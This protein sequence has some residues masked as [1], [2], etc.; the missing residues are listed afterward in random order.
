LNQPKAESLPKID[1]ETYRLENGL[2]VILHRDVKLP[3]VHVNLWYHVGSKNEEEGKT[4]F[5]H[6]FEHM[7][8]EGSRN[9]KGSFVSFMERAGAN[10]SQGGINGTTN[11]DRTNYFETVPAGSLPLV[12]WA[13]SDRMG[14]LLDAVNQENFDNQREVVKNERRQSMDNV[15]YGTAV[16]VIFQNL[17]PKGHPY[18]W[19]II[20]SMR[21]LENAS[22]KDVHQFFR[23]YYTPNNCVLTIA[24]EFETDEAKRLVEEYFG[25]LPP[26]PPLKRQRKWEITLATEPRIV[27]FDRVPQDRL[28]LAWPGV[29]YFEKDDAAL[30]LLTTLLADGKNSRLYKR[31]VYDEQVASDVSAFNYSLEV[32]GLVGVVATARPGVELSKLERMIDEE[33]SKVAKEGPTAEELE[34]LLAGQEFDFIS[35]LE[36]I[37]GFGGKADRLAM[38]QTFL[39]SPDRFQEDYERYQRIK[40]KDVKYV[41]KKYL[42][43][44]RLAI[45]YLPE[46]SQAVDKREPDRSTSPG[47]KPTPSFHLP[48]VAA[49]ILANGL[50][51]LVV[52]RREV[53]KVAASLLLKRG[54]SAEPAGRSGLASMTADMLEEGTTTRTSLQIEAELDRL[55]SHLSAG[56]SREW[57]AVSLDCLKR[58]LPES[59]DLLADVML[60]PSF[61]SEELERLRKQR[62]DGILQERMSPGAIAGKAV[63]KALFGRTHPYGWPVAG[64]ESSVREMK[65]AEL[66]QFYLKH[67]APSESAL[68]VV[69]DISLDEAE[70][71]AERV[72]G[73][74]TVDSFGE[75]KVEPVPPPSRK[76]YFADRPGAAQS[77]V[78]LAM[79]GPPRETPDY[80]VLE[81][82]NTLLGGGFSGRLNLNLREDKGY[83]YGAFSSIRYGNVQSVLLSSAPVESS[84]TKEAILEMLK[85]VE[86]LHGW[87]R[88]VTA[89]ELAHA[90]ENLVRGFAQRFETLSQIA[91]E[92][93]ELEGFGRK[94]EEL[95]DYTDA[96]ESVTLGN[97]EE[98]SSKYLDS[99]RSILVV[100]GDRAK[101]AEE[102]LALDFGPLV[103]LDADGDP[104]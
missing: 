21:D 81:V 73:G 13:E 63:R 47:L 45:E 27:V 1:F 86:D 20:G 35:G 18:S 55:G 61:P 16:E 37:G 74:W 56:G 53:P 87:R 90:K 36:R 51:L 2:R 67:Y 48:Q 11:F 79:L 60:H 77:E 9:V 8:F 23:R 17:F 39:G 54:A 88:P 68:I 12:L 75:V 101:I 33:I 65:R 98:A 69:G 40:A 14:Y 24:G 96:V 64:E 43:E 26:G 32:A 19:H 97:L 30:D 76:T 25:S 92:I 29:A 84:V 22:L 6:L 44:P 15:P 100:V 95:R 71:A 4:G 70:R 5:A 80:H 31:L 72:V 42:L 83:T 3:V 49:S 93:A 58:H 46:A 94:P 7:M 66:E 85:E 59:F 104:M 41:A 78:R 10:I 38:Y 34:R 89:E 52:E 82:L 91:G 102:L 50:K 99:A 62:L 57:S 28:Y 103:R